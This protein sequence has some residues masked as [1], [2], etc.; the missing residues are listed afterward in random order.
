MMP[1]RKKGKRYCNEI[2]HYC[3]DCEI[4]YSKCEIVLPFIGVEWID[5]VTLK[6]KYKVFNKDLDNIIYKCSHCGNDISDDRFLLPGD[7]YRQYYG[8]LSRPLHIK[9]TRREGSNEFVEKIE[10]IIFDTLL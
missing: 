10:E 3:T 2:L 1:S 5:P 8:V 6:T 4:L 9:L 7:I